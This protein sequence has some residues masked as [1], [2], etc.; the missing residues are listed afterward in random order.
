MVA[1]AALNS[2]FAGRALDRLVQGSSR[3]QILA[4]GSEIVGWPE[5]LRLTTEAQQKVQDARTEARRSLGGVFI[6]ETA[7]SLG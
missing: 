7:L 4:G 6:V 5:P 3:R 1:R 2:L